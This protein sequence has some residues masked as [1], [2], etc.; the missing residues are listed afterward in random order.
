MIVLYEADGNI[1]VG[2]GNLLHQG[3]HMGALCHG[4][5]KEFLPRRRV[6]KQVSGND[7]GTIRGAYFLQPLLNPAFNLV[8]GTG[9]AVP[10]LC[11]QLHLG[12]G[13]YAG[14]GL[15]AETQGGNGE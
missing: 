9:K 4:C 5:L 1:R 7:G 3:R 11:N 8:P 14:Q 15:A 12:H 10:R 2:K 13:R 6:V